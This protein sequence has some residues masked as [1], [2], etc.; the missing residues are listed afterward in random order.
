MFVLKMIESVITFVALVLITA[1]ATILSAITGV[2][3]I[4]IKWFN[5]FMILGGAISIVSGEWMLFRQIIAILAI[6][7]IVIAIVRCTAGIFKRVAIK[8]ASV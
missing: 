8:D 7:F 1:I 4:V 3:S 5:G 2:I 6:E